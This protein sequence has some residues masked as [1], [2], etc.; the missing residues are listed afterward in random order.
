MT[1]LLPEG[2]SRRYCEDWIF[3]GR[4]CPNEFGLCPGRHAHFYFVQSDDRDMIADHIANT[5]GLFF[6]ER[7]V[8]SL[9]EPHHRAKLRRDPPGTN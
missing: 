7:D 4:E 1:N 6:N 5:D 9:T 2:T 3:V 8:R